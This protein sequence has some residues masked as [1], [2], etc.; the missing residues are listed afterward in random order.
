MSRR[1]RG[2]VWPAAIEMTRLKDGL[3]SKDYWTVSKKE[4]L[5]HKK[6]QSDL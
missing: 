5:K 3:K 6:F 1:E 4:T 2:F